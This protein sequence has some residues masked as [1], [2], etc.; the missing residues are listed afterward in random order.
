[1]NSVM[2]I[3]IKAKVSAHTR[4]TKRGKIVQVR[5]H[6]DTRTKAQKLP[7]KKSPVQ[8]W[9]FDVSYGG[10]SYVTTH[11]D[12]K[13]R[14]IT[15]LGDGSDHA[16]GLK[17][18]NI[19][20]AAF[21]KVQQQHG[22]FHYNRQGESLTPE[23]QSLK[24]AK[25]AAANAAHA[26]SEAKKSMNGDNT[27]ETVNL[28]KYPALQKAIDTETPMR[29]SVDFKKK[30]KEIKSAIMVKIGTCQVELHAMLLDNTVK[31]A[32]AEDLRDDLGTGGV[33]VAAAKV[34]T[35]EPYNIRA[36]R[37]EIENLERIERNLDPKRTY[38]LSEYELRE[39]GF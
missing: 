16:R 19:T 12:L 17:T 20:A 22:K 27:M 25:L 7:P 36:K 29:K 8:A 6:Q 21:K 35:K 2:P 24:D 13:G 14:G 28:D 18:Y 39:Y 15:Q 10:S 11:L 31:L 3:M 38:T 26:K 30:G 23:E 32:A 4:R 33:E 5:E 1:M 37:K 34:E 9:E